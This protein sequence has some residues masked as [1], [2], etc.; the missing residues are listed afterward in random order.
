MSLEPWDEVWRRN[1][2]LAARLVTSGAVASLVFVTPPAGGLALRARRYSP[3]PGVEVVTPPLVIPRRYGGHRV[4]GAWSRR[5]LSDVDV[6]WINDPVVGVAAL[7]PGRPAVYDVTD[8]WRS[9]AQV[10]RQ[11]RRLVAAENALSKRAATVVCSGVLAE[12]WLQ[13]YG[14]S[15]TMIQNGVDVAGIR[16]AER[17]PLPGPGPHAVYV[18]TL[19]ANRIDV[20]LVADLAGKFPGTVH[21]VGPNHLSLVDQDKLQSSGVLLHGPV[22][23]SLVPDWMVS[24]DVLIC[25]HVVDAFTLSLDAIK[26]HEYLA[27]DRPIVATPSSGFQSRTEWGLLVVDR[28]GFGEAVLQGLGM[29]NHQR[30]VSADWAQRATDFVSVLQRSQGSVIDRVSGQQADPARSD[31]RD[32]AH[33]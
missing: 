24:A 14:V 3:L 12:R 23:A 7:R 17:R 26:S 1:Q 29:G 28:S 16:A 19:H 10:P 4:L 20:D 6:L 30:A 13:R 2:H 22:R 9:M 18:G 11:R 31:G 32:I 25:P 8:D 5:A 33:I 15:A 21:L 27:T